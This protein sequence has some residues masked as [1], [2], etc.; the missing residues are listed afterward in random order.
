V[1]WRYG[2][3]D[4]FHLWC[5]AHYLA[6]GQA[7]YDRP[8]RLKT[9]SNPL[10]LIQSHSRLMKRSPQQI[11]RVDSHHRG[12]LRPRFEPTFETQLDRLSSLG[13][14]PVPRRL[15]YLPGLAGRRGLR[16]ALHIDAAL[17][18]P[19]RRVAVGHQRHINQ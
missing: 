9:G 3:V 2:A 6:V 17:I 19:E 7:E 5:H 4:G 14:R 18:E 15:L 8:I 12:S 1:V 10:N 13:L 11:L 16:R